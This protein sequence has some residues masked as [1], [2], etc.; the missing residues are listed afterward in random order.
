MARRWAGQWDHT[1]IEALRPEVANCTSKQI[2]AVLNQIGRIT[3]FTA[4]ACWRE[5]LAMARDL[6]PPA[7]DSTPSRPLEDGQTSTLE[8]DPRLGEDHG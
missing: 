7:T 2:K 6:S 8:W 3:S 5:F 1:A 4:T